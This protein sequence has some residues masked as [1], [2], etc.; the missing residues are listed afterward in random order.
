MTMRG[1][2]SCYLAVVLCAGA[3]GAG[4]YHVL[5]REHAA[6]APTATAA[7]AIHVAD[8]QAAAPQQAQVTPVVTAA[9]GAQA[10]PGLAALPSGEFGAAPPPAAPTHPAILAGR[11]IVHHEVP[12]L[13]A[14]TPLHRRTIVASAQHEV[15]VERPRPAVAPPP[16]PPPTRYASYPARYPYAYAYPYPY[17]GYYAYAPRYGYYYRSF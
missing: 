13:A 3:A 8:D 16:P 10:A 12:R 9:G 5:Q 6:R 2:L 17:T 15:P 4:A 14:R 7:T 11:P 1:F